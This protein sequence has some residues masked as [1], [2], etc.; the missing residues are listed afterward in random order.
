MVGGFSPKVI[1]AGDPQVTG[2]LVGS[3]TVQPI[4]PAGT[5]FPEGPTATAVKVITCPRTG[6]RVEDNVTT[7]VNVETFNVTE[8]EVAAT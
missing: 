2:A 4:L 3:R 1:T 5:G 7:G 6:F 8:L